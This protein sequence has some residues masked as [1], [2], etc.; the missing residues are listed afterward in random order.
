MPVVPTGRSKTLC[1]LHTQHAHTHSQAEPDEV[2]LMDRAFLK[3][4]EK[5]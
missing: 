3:L 2:S 5:L 1:T 4:V